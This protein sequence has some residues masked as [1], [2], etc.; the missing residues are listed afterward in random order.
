QSPNNVIGANFLIENI[1]PLIYQQHPE[2]RLIIAGKSP[3]NIRTYSDNIPGVEFTGFVP[4][5]NALYDQTRVVCCPI[6]SGGGTRLKIIE[7]AAYG[8]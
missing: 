6:L 8:K 3:E 2:A 4:D 7:A 1:W 5:I